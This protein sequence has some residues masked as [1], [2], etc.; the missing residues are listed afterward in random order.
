MRADFPIDKPTRHDCDPGML[1]TPDGDFILK[2]YL[3]VLGTEETPEDMK[4]SSAHADAIIGLQ[5]IRLRENKES[6][7]KATLWAI[8]LAT[9]AFCE[10][11]IIAYLGSKP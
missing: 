5:A 6:L 1:L 11:V 8:W 10:L 3:D 2:G 9:I 7:R 4:V